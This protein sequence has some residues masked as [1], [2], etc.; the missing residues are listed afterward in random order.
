MSSHLWSLDAEVVFRTLL[1]GLQVKLVLSLLRE[2]LPAPVQKVIYGIR[3]EVPDRHQKGPPTPSSP[4][5]QSILSTLVYPCPL[6]VLRWRTFAIATKNMQLKRADDRLAPRTLGTS[7]SVNSAPCYQ[8]KNGVSITF[9]HKSA[10]QV[11]T[12]KNHWIEQRWLWDE[13]IKNSVF[14]SAESY[15]KNVI[16]F[17]ST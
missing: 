9:T 13:A 8:P 16:Y 17:V 11:I 10:I 1:R 6:T 5:Q 2:F 15:Q 7:F 12:A 14:S 3:P 4:C